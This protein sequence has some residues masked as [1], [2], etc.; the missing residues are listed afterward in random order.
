ILRGIK[1]PMDCNAFGKMCTPR[2]PIG[3]CMVSKEG[4]CDIVYSTKEL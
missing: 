4:S 3:P 2:T 1:S